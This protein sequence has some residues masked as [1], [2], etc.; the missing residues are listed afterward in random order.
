MNSDELRNWATV[1]TAAVALLVFVFNSLGGIR[2]RRVENVSRFNESHLR[3]FAFNGYI[4]RNLRAI[5]DG[6]MVR[7]PAN[8]EME[9]AFHLTLLEIERLAILAN[10]G[11]VPRLTQVYMFGAYARSLSK[12]ISKQERETMTW[13]LA[14]AYLDGLARD[15]D[16]YETLKPDQRTKFWR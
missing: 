7:D 3:L 12:L 9:A 8:A 13:E 2:N 1:I 5:E 16:G 4:A 10:N 11:A 6:S 14:V 15:T